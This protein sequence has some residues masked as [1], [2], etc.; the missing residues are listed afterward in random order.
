MIP[1]NWTQPFQHLQINLFEFFGVLQ[2]HMFLSN[3]S[4]HEQ[5]STLFSWRNITHPPSA[6]NGIGYHEQR[7]GIF[8]PGSF[9]RSNVGVRVTF[10]PW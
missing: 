1:Q 8:F 7:E 3:A 6:Y 5:F 2:S 10:Q 4:G 9:H